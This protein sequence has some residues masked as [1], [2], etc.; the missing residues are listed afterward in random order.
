MGHNNF[1]QFE[2]NLNKLKAV[3]M[4]FIKNQK[5]RVMWKT[6][7]PTPWFAHFSDVKVPHYNNGVRA[8]FKYKYQ[9]I[10]HIAIYFLRT[11]N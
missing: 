5:T 10:K 2:K 6:Q 1:A 4:N 8:I 3:L 7:P 9:S 11:L